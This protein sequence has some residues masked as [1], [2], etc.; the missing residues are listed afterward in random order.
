MGRKKNGIPAELTRVR[1]ANTDGPAAVDKFAASRAWLDEQVAAAPKIGMDFKGH[2]E[3]DKTIVL[4]KV[5]IKYVLTDPD[6]AKFMLEK[7]NLKSKTD[8]NRKI[9]EGTV[10][11]YTKDMRER[12]WM[13]DT[14]QG[15]KVSKEGWLNDGQHTL[16]AIVA[17]NKPL[18]VLWMIGLRRETMEA[19][20]GGKNRT[21]ADNVT[22][23]GWDYAPERARFAGL[24]DEGG[25]IAG[26]TRT[27]RQQKMA[28]QKST[29]TRALKTL[30]KGSLTGTKGTGNS[31]PK[32]L[33]VKTKTILLDH[34]AA[35]D[36]VDTFLVNFFS[37]KHLD[38]A[39]SWVRNY[40][41]TNGSAEKS[42]NP[43]Q[44]TNLHAVLH[45]WNSD[46]FGV[47]WRRPKKNPDTGKVIFPFPDKIVVAHEE[48]AA[49]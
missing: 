9:S 16:S 13:T 49:E 43:R 8:K 45:A 33:L 46:L 25:T 28:Q 38:D 31:Y 22:R 47:K 18:W 36:Q 39:G 1:T 5:I 42:S 15:V 12:R 30:P 6:L 48:D 3:N 23:Q 40:V 32:A 26:M 37:G 10:A 24:N 20:D 27:E 14:G 44:T 7:R 41:I 11:N 34:G 21:A 2:D 35:S 29:F 4:S 17:Y 19:L